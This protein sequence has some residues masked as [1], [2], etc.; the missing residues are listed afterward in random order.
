MRFWDHHWEVQ[1]EHHRFIHLDTRKTGAASRTSVPQHLQATAWMLRRIGIPEVRAS[2]RC[3][4]AARGLGKHGTG[5]GKQTC[6]SFGAEIPI[7][8]QE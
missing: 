4:A 6:V 7:Q 5:T 3:G 2:S 1:K 8:K